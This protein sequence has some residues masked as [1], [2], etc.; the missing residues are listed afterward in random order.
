[1]QKQYNDEF[2]AKQIEYYKNMVNP[3][4][5]AN[6]L[7]RI[8]HILTNFT[9]NNEIIKSNRYVVDHLICATDNINDA[10]IEVLVSQ[11]KK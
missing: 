1:M 8:K 10:M 9:T 2:E 5:I 3:Q 6:E 11:E 7:R 4:D